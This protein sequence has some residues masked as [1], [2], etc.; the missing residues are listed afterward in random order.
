[1]KTQIY[2]R[3]R[4]QKVEMTKAI[5]S[6]LAVAQIPSMSIIQCNKIKRKR[7]LI[8]INREKR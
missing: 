2:P 1:M 7:K 8:K 4:F 3:K 5:N 6:Y